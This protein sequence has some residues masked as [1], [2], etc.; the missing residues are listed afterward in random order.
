MNN[1]T[2]VIEFLVSSEEEGFR[3]DKALSLYDRTLSRSY[4]K[5]LILNQITNSLALILQ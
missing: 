3:V 5:K 2:K 1:S 4:L